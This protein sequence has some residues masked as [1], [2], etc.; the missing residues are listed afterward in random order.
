MH[1]RATPLPRQS[2]YV[3]GVAAVAALTAGCW[4]IAPMIGYNTSQRDRTPR[5]RLPVSAKKAP[6]HS[7][8]LVERLLRVC[9]ASLVISWSRYRAAAGPLVALLM[10]L[11]YAAHFRCPRCR[12]RVGLHSRAA[13]HPL[14]IQRVA[15][16]CSRCG[17][18]FETPLNQRARSNQAL[19]PTA[20]VPLPREKP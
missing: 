7:L 4:F 14:S 19:Q 13:G 18:S 8:H 20:T 15:Q 12:A 11:L 3:T 16:E 9:G 10:V 6:H 5:L 1:T 2:E 17:L